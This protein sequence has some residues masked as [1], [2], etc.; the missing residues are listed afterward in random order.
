M[1]TKISKKISSEF[2]KHNII[3]DDLVDV[4]KYGIEITLSTIIGLILTVVIGLLLSSLIQSMLFYVVFIALRSMTGGYHA[5][6]YFK[7]NLTFSL[8]VIFVI[9]FSK[10][11]CEMNISFGALT[12]LF[13]PSVL[14]FI[15]L[16][17]VENINKPIE[18]KKRVY[19]KIMAVIAS[20]L[21]YFLS[22]FLFINQH[23][24]EATVI[25]TTVFSVSVLCMIPIIQKEGNVNEKL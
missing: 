13:L 8:I 4:Y 18:K 22:I 15:W 5:K 3:S 2:V 23:K 1:I 7:C 20:I 14:S 24:L 9:I 25:I 16:A 19:W 6:T 12:L 17:P 21:L 11:A 10:A